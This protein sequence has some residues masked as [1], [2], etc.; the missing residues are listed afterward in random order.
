MGRLDRHYKEGV[1]FVTYSTLISKGSKDGRGRPVHL[2]NEPEPAGGYANDD[3]DNEDGDDDD[4]DEFGQPGAPSLRLQPVCGVCSPEQAD[5]RLQGSRLSADPKQMR[6]ETQDHQGFG[7]RACRHSLST[8]HRT[9]VSPLR[10]AADAQARQS[11]CSTF[12]HPPAEAVWMACSG[13]S[14]AA[15]AAQEAGPG[16]GL[17]GLRAQPAEPAGPVA[18][19]RPSCEVKG[20]QASQVPMPATCLTC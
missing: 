12:A 10:Q 3:S 18:A 5:L 11:R 15:E 8:L 4:R 19:R 2:P 1:V 6:L 9:A 17:R 16:Q 14:E 20:Q 7:R 13:A